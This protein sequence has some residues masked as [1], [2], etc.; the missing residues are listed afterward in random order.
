MPFV[1]SKER[2]KSTF[3]S[4]AQLTKAIHKDKSEAKESKKRHVTKMSH[5][6]EFECSNRVFIRKLEVEICVSE[7]ET[8]RKMTDVTLVRHQ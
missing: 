1:A 4:P 2:R 3:A 7:M 8:T 6:E 5:I